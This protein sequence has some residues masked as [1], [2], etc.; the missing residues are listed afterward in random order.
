MNP[1]ARKLLVLDL[2][3]TLVRATETALAHPADF[4]V[5]PYHVYKRPHLAAFLGEVLAAFDVGVWTS[6][7]E[8]YAAQ[9]IGRLFEPSALK[10]VWSSARCTAARDWTTGEY[11]TIKNLAKLRRQGYAL[12]SIVAV[13]DTVPFSQREDVESLDNLARGV[14]VPTL[15]VTNFSLLALEGGN[16]LHL[17]YPI[18]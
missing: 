1:C 11:T 14:L 12:E 18:I 13:D 7:G 2:G 15:K 4:A 9:V 6:S 17:C 3:E 8:R 16:G 5:G 10:F